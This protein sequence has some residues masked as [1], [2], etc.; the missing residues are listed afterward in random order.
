MKVWGCNFK[1]KNPE[2]FPGYTFKF[3]VKTLN[4]GAPGPLLVNVNIIVNS[5]Y[6]YTV[7]CSQK[8]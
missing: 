5:F 8:C 6:A 1:D 2:F 7:R 3:V 4:G